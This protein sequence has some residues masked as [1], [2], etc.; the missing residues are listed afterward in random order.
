MPTVL[1]DSSRW[2]GKA[3]F[4]GDDGKR[5]WLH[6]STEVSVGGGGRGQRRKMA[7][8]FVDDVDDGIKENDV[9]SSLRSN[10]IFNVASQ[11]ISV[12][13]F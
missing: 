6:L 2:W 11:Q 9:V 4:D 5:R 3:L 1:G 12:E 13:I 7:G 10:P 8:A